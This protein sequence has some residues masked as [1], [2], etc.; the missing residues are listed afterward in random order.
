VW[1]SDDPKYPRVDVYGSIAAGSVSATEP[2]FRTKL[3]F[4]DRLENLR[5]PSFP[6][7]NRYEIS[8][9]DGRWTMEPQ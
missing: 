4:D 7:T 9:W 5:P 1:K 8:A 3:E 2:R 6:L